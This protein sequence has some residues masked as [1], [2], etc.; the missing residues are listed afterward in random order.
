MSHTGAKRTTVTMLV[1]LLVASHV[2]MIGVEAFA[3]A[4]RRLRWLAHSTLPAGR[5][6]EDTISEVGML[7]KLSDLAE[8]YV[9]VKR[10]GRT[11]T[12]CC[13]FHDDTRPS[14]VSGR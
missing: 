4:P 1:Q 14:M 7:A 2:A 6:S 3:P 5:I 13:P 8:A 12:A 11:V 9:V 10:S